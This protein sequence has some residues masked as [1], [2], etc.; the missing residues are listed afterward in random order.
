VLA[1]IEW[2]K[3]NLH[4][5]VTIEIPPMCPDMRPD[6]C[7]PDRSA[8]APPARPPARHRV[9][10]ALSHARATRPK[11]KKDEFDW[12][13]YVAGK[14]KLLA[15]LLSAA[16]AAP[17]SLEADLP[18]SGW[19]ADGSAL[20]LGGTAFSWCLPAD[21][22]PRPCIRGAAESARLTP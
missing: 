8:Q 18:T 12:A 4:P 13:P 22:P 3:A 17:V 5:D 1:G 16:E 10:G 14:G 6:T 19:F 21:P 11:P 20:T 15:A 9:A 2:A 7:F